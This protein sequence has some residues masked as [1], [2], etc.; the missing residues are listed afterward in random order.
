MTKKPFGRFAWLIN[1]ALNLANI[2]FIG[3]ILWRSLIGAVVGAVIFG[4]LGITV[5][6]GALIGAGLSILALFFDEHEGLFNQDYGTGAPIG[7]LETEAV[8]KSIAIGKTKAGRQI[9]IQCPLSVVF[10]YVSDFS[11]YPEWTTSVKP[12]IQQLSPESTGMGAKFQMREAAIG[13]SGIFIL[14]I[15]EWV[16]NYKIAYQRSTRD[17]KMVAKIV[18]GYYLFA[19]AISNSAHTVVTHVIQ[20]Q[21]RRGWGWTK[22]PYEHAIAEDLFK[23]KQKLER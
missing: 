8:D 22:V 7:W 13:N 23:L 14:E 10:S 12:K 1:I 17:K 15:T 3:L 20:L 4:L 19:P 11:R 16:S 2:I 9:T 21:A 18:G 5:W 6:Y